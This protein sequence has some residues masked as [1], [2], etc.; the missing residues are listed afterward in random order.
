MFTVQLH[1][2]D[3]DKLFTQ[4]PFEFETFIIGQFGGIPQNKRGGDKGIDGKMPDNTPV[5]VKQQENVGR[6]VVERAFRRRNSKRVS[7]L[8]P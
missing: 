8:S 5:Q 6:D 2:Y 1:K 4:N 3:R 7:T